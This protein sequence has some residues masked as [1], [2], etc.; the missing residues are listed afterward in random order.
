MAD[1]AGFCG[2]CGARQTPTASSKASS[3]WANI[4]DRKA[5]M[6]CYI[7]VVGWIPSIVVLA[8]DKFRE[9]RTVRFHA[10]QGLY[11]FV[12]WLIVD[13]A[14]GSMFSFGPRHFGFEGMMK[15]GLVCVWVFMILKTSQRVL[16][17]LPLVGELAE[18]SL[19]EQR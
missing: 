5:S 6:L 14:F 17:R 3:F 9:D 7:P 1:N 19:S 4:D 13:W 15:V 12:A 18:R 16:Y 8:S 10:F 11:L 2:V